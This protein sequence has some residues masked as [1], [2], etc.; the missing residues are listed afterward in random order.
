MD[1]QVR[2]KYNSLFSNF[3]VTCVEYFNWC[4]KN[5][6]PTK[7]GYDDIEINDYVENLIDYSLQNNPEDI[8]SDIFYI[9]NLQIQL[10]TELKQLIYK[11]NYGC[12][13]DITL[14]ILQEYNIKSNF[15]HIVKLGL[16][17][18][19]ERINIFVSFTELIDYVL[20]HIT[21]FGIKISNVSTLHSYITNIVKDK[22]IH[23]DTLTQV[24]NCL[25]DVGKIKLTVNINELFVRN[26]L[27]KQLNGQIEISTPVG[28]IDVLT[29]SEIIEIKQ[30]CKFKDGIG[31]LISYGFYYPNHQKRLHLFGNYE[32]IN[33][34]SISEVCNAYNIKLT[35][36]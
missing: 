28:R 30:A 34:S 22:L 24:V 32:N 31:Q 9:K 11:T 7:L 2:V 8:M 14:I 20:D 12:I 29:N 27:A 13:E 10:N 16:L 19:L 1:S 23:I 35:F 33:V 4:I 26:N 6:I 5:R 36:E 17:D 3:K 18:Y 21:N 25:I 15:Y